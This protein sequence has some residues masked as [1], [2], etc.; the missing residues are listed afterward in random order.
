MVQVL[1]DLISHCEDHTSYLRGVELSPGVFECGEV[2]VDLAY[3]CQDVLGSVEETGSK[4]PA[5][6]VTGQEVSAIIRER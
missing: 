4:L 5:W 6:Q 3:V 2:G 1:L